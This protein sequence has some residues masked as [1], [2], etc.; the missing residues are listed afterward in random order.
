M[1]LHLYSPASALE[2]MFKMHV[3]PLAPVAGNSVL[4]KYNSKEVGVPPVTDALQ[5]TVRV[6]PTVT[7]S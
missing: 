6:S 5:I 3:S 4:P 7:V 1:T 2:V